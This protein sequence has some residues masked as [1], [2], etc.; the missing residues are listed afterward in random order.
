MTLPFRFEL[1]PLG[2]SRV[3]SRCLV[4][5]LESGGPPIYK[6]GLTMSF[7]QASTTIAQLRRSRDGYFS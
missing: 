7:L 4:L 5:Q 1:K 3:N 2:C 6:P